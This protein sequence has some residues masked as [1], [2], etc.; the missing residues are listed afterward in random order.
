MSKVHALYVRQAGVALLKRAAPPTL[1]GPIPAASVFPEQRPA[2]VSWPFVAWGA[3][4]EVPFLASGLDGSTVNVAVHA[5]AETTGEGDDT[6]PGADMANVL[7]AWVIATLGGE[8]GAEV[9]LAETDCPHP[10]TAYFTYT[11]SQC[12]QDGG[13]PNAFHAWATFDVA[14]RS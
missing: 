11:G 4:T 3:P 5:Y 10:A 2:N 13:D 1:P 8:D 6:R 14:V 12:V 7:I 9:S